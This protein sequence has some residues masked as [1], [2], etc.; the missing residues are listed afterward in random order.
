MLFT[1]GSRGQECGQEEA[2][3]AGPHGLKYKARQVRGAA[4]SEGRSAAIVKFIEC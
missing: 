4:E 1:A 2:I 3:Q